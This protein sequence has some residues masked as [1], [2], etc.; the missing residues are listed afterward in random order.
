MEE[1][2][3]E[4]TKGTKHE[5][6]RERE[7]LRGKQRSNTSLTCRVLKAHCPV[8]NMGSYFI[9]FFFYYL[10]FKMMKTCIRAGEY[11]INV[12]RPLNTSLCVPVIA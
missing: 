12:H 9:F 11:E 1:E 5:R 2:E 10:H 6:E 8:R 4:D 3:E 7:R